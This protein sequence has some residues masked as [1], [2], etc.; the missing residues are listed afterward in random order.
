[1]EDAMLVPVLADPEI[2]RVFMDV[3][4]AA[5]DVT[6]LPPPSFSTIEALD[7]W[8]H[9]LWVSRRAEHVAEAAE[10]ARFRRDSLEA[11]Y[12]ARMAILD[13]QRGRANEERIR[14]MRTGQIDRAMADHR[15]ALARLARDEAR[16][17]I[18]PRRVAAGS[19]STETTSRELLGLATPRNSR[20]Q[21]KSGASASDSNRS[22]SSPS[23]LRSIARPKEC[24]SPL[25]FGTWW[26]PS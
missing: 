2:S 13:E 22:M 14:R 24:R 3:L 21:T 10:I 5:R 23:D 20:K 11:S 4:A 25:G 7:G 17:D 18:L 1:M 6:D 26:F 19:R 9:D 16:A 8:H 15:E 12:S